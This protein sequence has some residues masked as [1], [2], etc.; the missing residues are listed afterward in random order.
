MCPCVKYP[1][2]D[3][4]AVIGHDQGRCSNRCMHWVSK[5]YNQRKQNH[6]AATSTEDS[7]NNSDDDSD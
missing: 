4:R 1:T 2:S 5:N 6:D 7:A 3:E